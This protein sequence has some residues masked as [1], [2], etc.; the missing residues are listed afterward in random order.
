MQYKCV[1][2]QEL[3]DSN[4][5]TPYCIVSDETKA[6]TMCVS[7]EQENPGFIFWYQVCEERE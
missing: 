7:L 4:I 5:A 2:M 3:E 1:I 6:E